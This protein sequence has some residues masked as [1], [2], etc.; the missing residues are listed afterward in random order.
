MK[1]RL[2]YLRFPFLVTDTPPPP[3]QL[4][5]IGSQNVEGKLNVSFFKFQEWQDWIE[6]EIFLGYKLAVFYLKPW[7][8]V[9]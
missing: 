1:K 8:P 3:Y 4:Y 6:F 5:D 9:M 2:F 7:N